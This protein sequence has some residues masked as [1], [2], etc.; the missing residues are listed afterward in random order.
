MLQDCD[1]LDRVE[2]LRSWF[3]FPISGNPFFFPQQSTL[4]DIDGKRSTIQTSKQPGAEGFELDKS[5]M[6]DVGRQP[7]LGPLEVEAVDDGS[8][9]VGRGITR[10]RY[11]K[12]R[13]VQ[14]LGAGKTL[15]P[16]A[17]AI[18]NDHTLLPKLPT[19]TRLGDSESGGR[20]RSTFGAHEITPVSRTVDTQG[21]VPNLVSRE[22]I[23]RIAIARQSLI[24]EQARVRE[25]SIEPERKERGGPYCR[26]RPS[27]AADVDSG[28]L[29]LRACD[30][31]PARRPSAFRRR[32]PG[33]KGSAT[34]GGKL[35]LR[36]TADVQGRHNMPSMMH[37]TAGLL[38]RP[39]PEPHPALGPV[40]LRSDCPGGELHPNP[41]LHTVAEDRFPD[42]G[43]LGEQ[44]VISSPRSL[45]VGTRNRCATAP[46]H[47]SS[48][49]RRSRRA[50]G[51]SVMDQP[52]RPATALARIPAT[53][54]LRRLSSRFDQKLLGCLTTER[55]VSVVRSS[56]P[57]DALSQ[58]RPERSASAWSGRMLGLSRKAGAELRALTAAGTTGRRQPPIREERQ[59]RLA[60]DV[61]RYSAELRRLVVEEEQLRRDLIRCF[62]TDRRQPERGD[63]CRGVEDIA[64]LGSGHAIPERV[65]VRQDGGTTRGIGISPMDTGTSACAKKRMESSLEEKRHEIECKTFSLSVKRDELRCLRIV[66]K[67]EH[68][69][70]DALELDGR[71]AHLGAGQVGEID[72]SRHR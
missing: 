30:S 41:F 32:A 16:Y 38:Q 53:E 18:I 7:W 13:R 61:V 69:R 5:G 24:E 70:K 33:R 46:M 31:T 22:D 65:S 6:A 35:E 29:G 39:S 71:R 60:R 58:E 62:C 48:Q 21:V 44:I 63:R 47:E 25:A 34:R 64:A 40:L 49:R 67:Q 26:R 42:S 59:R 27:E 15:A 9:I 52:P 37:T 68:E 51:P 72:E 1:F 4:S 56:C 12:K 19:P 11:S 20:Q 36:S 66:Q 50:S 14:K 43:D 10:G 45:C 8:D 54:S 57:G 55:D 28:C 2:T 23:R 17:A 3:G